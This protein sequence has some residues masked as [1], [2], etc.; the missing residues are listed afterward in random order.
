MTYSFIKELI[1]RRL[2]HLV[3]S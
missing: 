3:T 1:K 2:R